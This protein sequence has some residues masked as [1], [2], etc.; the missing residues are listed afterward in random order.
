M[1]ITWWCQWWMLHFN[2]EV[3]DW[4]TQDYRNMRELNKH[5]ARCVSDK[6]LTLKHGWYRTS[7]LN[8]TPANP[9]RWAGDE[10]I[11]KS[12]LRKDESA[13]SHDTY[14]WGQN[15]LNEKS[16][17]SFYFFQGNVTQCCFYT[18]PGIRLVVILS[19]RVC[20]LP[21]SRIQKHLEIAG[22][23]FGI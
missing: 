12:D 20:C 1:E 8:K 9:Y 2:A 10:Q 14:F 13:H 3:G 7:K 4:L 11:Y 22:W 6:G 17:I 21:L 18:A 5:H 16:Y 23:C 15:A 19:C